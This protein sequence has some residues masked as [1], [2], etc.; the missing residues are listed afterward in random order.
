MN[1]NIRVD[2]ITLSNS[3]RDYVNKCVSSS[4]KLLDEKARSSALYEVQLSRQTHHNKGDVFSA[5]INLSVDGEGRIGTRVTEEQ[6][7]TN[8]FLAEGRRESK[9]VDA[10][11]IWISVGAPLIGFEIS[12]K[13]LALSFRRDA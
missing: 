6:D 11:V 3:L 4:E 5:E 1:V 12:I 13:H 2:N 7:K 10:G 8:E 9:G